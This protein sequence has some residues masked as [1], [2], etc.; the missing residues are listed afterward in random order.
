MG[1]KGFITIALTVCVFAAFYFT[2]PAA[3]AISFASNY[4]P[5]TEA[6]ALVFHAAGC[7]TCHISPAAEYS[8]MPELAGGIAFPSQFGTFY[9]PNISPHPT[10]GIGA[11]DL[12]A[13]ASAVMLG[14]SPNGQHYYP[15]FPYLAYQ[16]MTVNDVA[17]LFEYIQ[18]LPASGTSS[19]SHDLIFPFNIRR[20]L[21]F[22][23][24]AFADNKYVKK[25]TKDPKIDRGTYLVE[26]LGHCAECHTPRNAAGALDKSQWMAGAPNLSGN[27]LVPNITPAVL[28]WTEADLIEYFTSGFTPEYD[29]AGGKMA[30]VI[31]NLSKL[32]QEDREA[33]AAYVLALK[34]L[35]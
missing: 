7:A 21:G 11:W 24:L 35:P 15:A 34:P 13:F 30:D 6:G 19:V 14:V 9:A 16:H 22:W 31:H 1:A 20:G 25:I 26:G 33:I 4:A 17:D 12:D 18:T 23:K 32:P 5:S 28:D 10:R 27:G 8:E 2:R 29:T 3:L